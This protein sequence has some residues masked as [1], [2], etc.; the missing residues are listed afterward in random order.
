MATAHINLSALTHNL[1][2]TRKFLKTG[3]EVL[4]AV[5]ANAYG[6]GAVPVVKHLESQGVTWFGVATSSE[7]LELRAGG[8]NAN[9]LMLMPVYEGLTELINADISLSVVD[10]YS[11][12]LIEQADS[13][14]Q[15]RVHLKVDTG[16]GRLGQSGEAAVTLAKKIDASA[17]ELE[18]VWT[19]FSCSD[20]TSEDYT[21]AQ[22]QAFNVF[23][24]SIEK[25]G[26]NPKLRHASNSAA[27]F[28]YPEAH[29]DLVRPGI[30]IYG[31]HSSPFIATLEPNLKPAL[32][33]HAPVTF[34][35]RIRAGTSVS[36]SSMWQA[37]KDTTIATV[38]IGYADGYPRLLTGKAEVVVQDK[39]CPVTGRIC[40]DQMMVDVGDLDIQV[41]DWVTLFGH[42]LLD[43]EE[44]AGR[45][46]TISYE[47]L[48]SLS[49]RIK[50]VY[51]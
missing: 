43:A 37:K 14:T 20:D 26:I 13:A 25:A 51:V 24:A 49:A 36:Y 50:R 9:I 3:T 48:T 21:E 31:H 41:G 5:K 47:L 32:S 33:L 22:I 30:C 45:I 4:V 18:G 10:D 11:L 39:L 34:V 40:M 15:A 17:V 27:I 2:H 23:L 38:R 1:E 44:L 12:A 42:D 16:M 46:G 8:V 6:H 28:A 29:Y 35:K 7:A 19:H